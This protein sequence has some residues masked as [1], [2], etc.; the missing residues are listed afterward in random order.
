[1]FEEKEGK[2][3]SSF[4]SAKRRWLLD[5]A[6]GLSTLVVI[7]SSVY[8]L[9]LP[10]GYQGGRNPN[11]GTIILFARQTWDVLHTW[12]GILMIWTALV[13][14]AVHW[15]WFLRMGR[16]IWWQ[17]GGKTG[18]LN[19]RGRINLWANF[20]LAASFVLC[21]LSGTYFMFVVGS[22]QVADPGFLFSR[23]IWDLIHTWSGI[24][25]FGA[26]L[27]HF[28][29]HWQWVINN[30]GRFVRSFRDLFQSIPVAGE[31]APQA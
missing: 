2:K 4:W 12:S 22:R 17:I 9:Y 8:F 30:A 11:Y 3:Q 5:A 20:M 19:T 7:V 18:Q 27:V 29:I 6:L 28:S 24:G 13:H 15:K 21:A 23:I 31:T 16:R 10:T 25:M 14:V 1:M 26:A